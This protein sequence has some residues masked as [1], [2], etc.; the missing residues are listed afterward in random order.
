[1]CIRPRQPTRQHAKS[2]LVS[3]LQNLTKNQ[4]APAPRPLSAKSKR[5][6]RTRN[7]YPV[8]TSSRELKNTRWETNQTAL[9]GEGLNREN[10]IGPDSEEPQRWE[11]FTEEIFVGKGAWAWSLRRYANPGRCAVDRQADDRRPVAQGFWRERIMSRQGKVQNLSVKICPPKNQLG[12]RR[13]GKELNGWLCLPFAIARARIF[14]DPDAGISRAC[15]T[16]AVYS[17]STPSRLNAPDEDEEEKSETVSRS[18]IARLVNKGR[19]AE[20]KEL[21]ASPEPRRK[22]NTQISGRGAFIFGISPVIGIA[23]TKRALEL[24]EFFM[25]SGMGKWRCLDP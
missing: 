18:E 2:I 15:G 11:Q 19:R 24:L 8:P 25:R 14:K 9:Q 22:M 7:Q 12:R 4:L 17:S 23:G 21:G 20:L 10:S 13:V 3:A 6:K 5:K 1:L 16:A